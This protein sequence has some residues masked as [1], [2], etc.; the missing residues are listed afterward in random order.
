MKSISL[1]KQLVLRLLILV[2][3]LWLLGLSLAGIQLTKELSSS[4]DS[5]LQETAE[6][7]LPLALVEIFNREE[8]KLLQQLPAL[9]AHEERL[10]YQVRNA[11]GQVL[12]QSHTAR[13]KKISVSLR[14]GF[15]NQDDYRVFTVSAVQGTYFIQVAEALSNRR[16]AVFNTLLSMAFPLLLLL[17]LCLLIAV[18]LVRQVIRPVKQYGMQLAQRGA[19][20]L[21]PIIPENLPHELEPMTQAVDQLMFRLQAA[22]EA[23]RHFTANAAHELRTPLATLMAQTQRLGKTLSDEV[24]RVKVD[25]LVITLNQLVNLSD[26]LL[27]LAK[28][29]SSGMLTSTPQDL[30]GLLSLIVDEYQRSGGIDIQLQL[31]RQV[32]KAC[33]D[34]DAF[35]ILVKN[36]IENAIK[37]GDMNSTIQVGLN[38]KGTLRVV[39]ACEPL[40]S[41]Q[42]K[43]LHERFYR[44]SKNTQGSGL[45]LAIVDAL[46]KSMEGRIELLSP[47]SGSD[48]GFEVVIELPIQS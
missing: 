1:Q 30:S 44:A 39:N 33:I 20:D 24:S 13:Q 15:E 22:L 2:T 32:I 37:H 38:L 11:S 9:S 10:S 23:E 8:T 29:D 18:F 46:V 34:A 12:L 16:E 19:S 47:A 27:Q 3:C 41:E 28:A 48:R 7:I 6:R 36:L 35:S 42:Q 21:T 25:K 40:T 31:P 4:F 17:P 45:G 26:K 43:R 14:D 5:A